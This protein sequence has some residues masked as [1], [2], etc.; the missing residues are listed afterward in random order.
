MLAVLSGSEGSQVPLII[1]LMQNKLYGPKIRKAMK[2]GYKKG[3]EQGLR[4][5]GRQQ[6]A[7]KVFSRV[8]EQRFGPL[9]ASAKRSL[10]AMSV[11]QL[12]E[13]APSVFQATSLKDLLK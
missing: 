13:L 12:L 4:E 7:L 11:S 3:F 8:L 10:S 2:E 5:V 9:P 1:N 6:G